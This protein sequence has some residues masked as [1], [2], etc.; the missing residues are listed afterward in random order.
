MSV[1][2]NEMKPNVKELDVVEV[3]VESE[4]ER[5]LKKREARVVRK[6]DLCLMP[7]LLIL[8]LL[9]FLDRGNIGFAASQGMI[10]DI[11][12]K[13]NQ[14]NIAVSI[15]YVFYII[16]EIPCSLMAKRLQ[17]NRVIPG[18]SLS[19]GLVCLAN[20]FVKNFAGLAVCRL[21]L[22][23]FEGFLFPSMVLMMANYYRREELGY[24]V[25]WVY[26]CIAVSSAFGGLIAFAIL[27]MN[28]VANYPG[29]RWLYIIE[30]LFTVIFAIACF[31]LIP[32]DYQTAWFFTPEEKEIMRA[33]DDETRA[34]SGGS[35]HYKK[36]DVMMAV[37]DIK[38]WLYAFIQMFCMTMVYGFSVF[39]PIILK[40][41]FKYDT[42]QAQ[43]LA[44]PVF[45]WGAIV[46]TTVGYLSGRHQSKFLAVAPLAPFAMAGYAILLVPTTSISVGVRYFACFLIT[47]G[48]FCCAAGNFAWMSCNTAPEGKRAATIGITLTLTN[49][50][51]IISGQIYI[52]DQAPRF[53][54]GQAF[55]LACAVLAVGGW[56]W[57]R[58]LFNRRE[59][60]K[61]RLREE[62]HVPA[63]DGSVFEISDRD[64]AYRY[65]I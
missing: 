62:G 18:V 65:Q 55:S 23:L 33:R 21:L 30:G 2:S 50:G 16:A 7:T 49:I 9:G 38:T 48:I 27:Y 13:G 42:K 43:Y 8:M 47:T 12:L 59:A 22:G 64:T 1:H 24:R 54:A 3:P 35:G 56:C 26:I 31:W 19:W 20:G 25:G 46:L 4:Q 14:L 60:E 53:Q 32:K 17:Y 39:L 41:G 63:T 10:Q 45:L 34:Y 15:F 28:G 51:G 6:I 40:N 37:K 29:W 61:A 5:E 57:L 44:V 52:L 11:G 36:K 58:V